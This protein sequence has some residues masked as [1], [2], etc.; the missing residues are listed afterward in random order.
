M[1]K[2]FKNGLS[3]LALIAFVLVLSG[4]GKPATLEEFLKNNNDV[5][6]EINQIAEE[7]AL[8]IEIKDNEIIFTYDVSAISSFTEENVFTDEVKTA[9]KSALDGTSATFSSLAKSL[10][11]ES[12]ISGIRLTVKYTFN[13]T[14]IV[15]R[16]FTAE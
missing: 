15:E 10:E 13:G 12:K 3:M 5:M 8:A 16:T 11:E 1:K 2:L 14:L 7:S 9:F 6:Q 4:C